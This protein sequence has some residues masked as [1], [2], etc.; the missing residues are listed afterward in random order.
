ML[1]GSESQPCFSRTVPDVAH[2]WVYLRMLTCRAI[3]AASMPIGLSESFPEGG[4]EMPVCSEVGAP[5]E[6]L[7]DRV[8]S[9]TACVRLGQSSPARNVCW[10]SFY[11]RHVVSVWQGGS[12][13]QQIHYGSRAVRGQCSLGCRV[14][15]CQKD[16]FLMLLNVDLSTSPNTAR[17]QPGAH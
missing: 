10:A 1:R 13:Q 2:I 11:C 14:R 3:V 5:S 8:D 12:N 7:H 4:G 9:E 15:L 16:T 6:S 17:K